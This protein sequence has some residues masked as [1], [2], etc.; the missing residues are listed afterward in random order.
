MAV[1]EMSRESRPALDH[2]H[3]HCP[4]VERLRA[5]I[6]KIAAKANDHSLSAKQIVDSLRRIIELSQV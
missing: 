6:E 2:E 4:C 5:A 1:Q 3:G